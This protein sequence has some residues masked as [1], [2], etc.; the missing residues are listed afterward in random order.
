VPSEKAP[1]KAP[2]VDKEPPADPPIA[3]TPSGASAAPANPSGTTTAP[4]PAKEPIAIAPSGASAAPSGPT[5]VTGNDDEDTDPPL[6]KPDDGSNEDDRTPAPELITLS[7]REVPAIRTVADAR[8]LLRKGDADGA[9]A[10]LYRLRRTKPAPPAVRSSEIASL[11][12]SIYF[13]RR[14][15]TDALREYR[16]AITLDGRARKNDAL[17]GNSVRALAERT[18]YARAR[19]LILEYV[20]RNASPALRRAA[21]SG[22]TPA[23]RRRAQKVLATLESKS[24]RLRR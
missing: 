16:F 20:G 15:W 6:G 22:A 18:T 11:I 21:K 10:G 24:Y 19:R 8:A 13:E 3:E 14:W 1:E 12:G 17:V 9:L 4:P 7:R 5:V 2:A 23:L